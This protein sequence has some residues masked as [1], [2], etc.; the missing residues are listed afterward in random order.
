MTAHKK[1]S[2]STVALLAA[3]HQMAED[4]E[5]IGVALV[6]VKR[7]Y[8]KPLVAFSGEAANRPFRTL[9][10]LQRLERQ[11]LDHAEQMGY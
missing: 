10:F 4:G 6:G 5:L 2:R 7:G 3:L 8:R 9:G 11:L 1:S